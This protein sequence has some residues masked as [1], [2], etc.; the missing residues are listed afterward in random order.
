MKKNLID[1]CFPEELK[2][3]DLKELELLS[4]EIRNFL[5]DKV[6]KTGGHLA[7]NLGV[8]E[9][10]IALHKFYNSPEDKIVWDVGHQSYV[11]KILTGRANRFDSLRQIDGISGFPKCCESQHDIFETGHASTSVAAGFGLAVARDLNNENHK[12]ISVIGD[13]ALS[14][15]LAYEGLNTAGDKDTDFT[16][17]L[18]D[19]NMSISRNV[20]AMSQHLGKLRTSQGYREFKNQLKKTIKHIP[21]VG[22]G[23]YT[24]LENIKDSIKYAVINDAAIFE[25]LGFKYIGPIDGHNIGDLIE[26]FQLVEQINGPKLIHIITQKGK[27]Y[28]NAENNPNK[29]HGIGPFERETGQVLSSSDNLSYSCIFANKLSELAAKD[30]AIV[31]VYAAMLEGT[32]LDIFYEKFPQRTFDVGIAEGEAVTF[33]AGLA[34]GGIKPFVVIYSTFLQRAYDMMMMDVCLQNLPV[35][36]CID[37][38]GIVGN[39]GETHHG[40]FDLSYLNHMPNMTVLSPK[41]RIELEEMMEYANQLDGPCAI[42]YPRGEAQLI[43]V[44]NKVP[45]EEGCEIIKEGKD[46]GIYAVGPMVKKALEASSILEYKGISAAVVNA[47]FV[48]PLPEK[49]ILGSI[50]FP[51]IVTVE[52]N[53]LAGGFGQNMNLFLNGN[54]QI[55]SKLNLGW[56][57]TFIE[58]GSQDQL[59]EKYRLDGKG[60][61]ERIEEFVKR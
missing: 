25:A 10:S 13:G 21:G 47:R 28:K 22:E 52:D 40:V 14:S 41:D 2:A 59:Y 15:G 3:M 16:V 6:S 20:G 55:Q 53:V 61:A 1:Y 51:K 9:L 35:V 5:I 60:I 24:G 18:N 45:L 26:V 39:D 49:S 58:Q 23:I 19:N 4:Y 12:V 29:F 7:S 56:P 11:H 44:I 43:S 54:K 34:K 46:V 48:K 27:G 38:A 8:V 31:A 17:I 30:P 42:R 37:R 33:A 50:D 57:D 32:S 36:F